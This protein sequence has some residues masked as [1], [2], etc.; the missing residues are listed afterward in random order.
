MPGPPPALVLVLP[1]LDLMCAEGAMALVGMVRSQS[2]PLH[3]IYKIYLNSKLTV[4]G[5]GGGEG[6]R[7]RY[8][9]R[10]EVLV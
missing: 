8:I 5:K 7:E 3:V 9:G 2:W 4:K 10:K 1:A 6:E